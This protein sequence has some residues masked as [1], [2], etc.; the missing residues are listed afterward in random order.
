MLTWEFLTDGLGAHV[1]IYELSPADDCHSLQILFWAFQCCSCAGLRLPQPGGPADSLSVLFPVFHLKTEA[2]SRF[3]NVV[4]LLFYNLYD[5]QSPGEQFCRLEVLLCNPA[6]NL[7]VFVRLFYT[8]KFYKIST[9]PYA[10]DKTTF[11][12]TT[13]RKHMC[14]LLSLGPKLRMRDKFAERHSKWWTS[15]L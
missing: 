14:I 3:R 15:R 9:V 12:H 7:N 1:C 4:V 8:S 10:C 2:E 11:V 13:Q 6:D 5:G